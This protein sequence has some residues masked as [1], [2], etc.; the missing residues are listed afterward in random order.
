MATQRSDT[1]GEVSYSTECSETAPLPLGTAS[2]ADTEPGEPATA[3]E[4][5][6]AGLSPGEPAESVHT[7]QPVYSADV[8][9]QREQDEPAAGHFECEPGEPVETEPCK[10]GPSGVPATMHPVSLSAS[11]VPNVGEEIAMLGP[12]A[13]AALCQRRRRDAGSSRNATHRAQTTIRTSTTP[14]NES[15]DPSIDYRGVEWGQ[16]VPQDEWERRVCVELNLA[17]DLRYEGKGARPECHACRRKSS[18]D[19]PLAKCVCCENWACTRHLVVPACLARVYAMCS[20]HPGMETR[21]HT[22]FS[23]LHKLW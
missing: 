6:L 22:N 1:S 9:S 23:Y 3:H 15:F 17:T 12:E 11:Q 21:P 18:R 10:G 5:A 19:V 2:M 7:G 16:P 20:V 8:L 13:G 4:L 14:F